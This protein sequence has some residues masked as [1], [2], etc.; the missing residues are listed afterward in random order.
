VVILSTLLTKDSTIRPAST[1]P[2]GQ[3]PVLTYL[4]Q[5]TG[6]SQHRLLPNIFVAFWE[7]FLY[8]YINNSFCGNAVKK[9]LE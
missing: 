8:T 1:L 4:L 2:G 9:L 3:P 7:A 5:K 6:I